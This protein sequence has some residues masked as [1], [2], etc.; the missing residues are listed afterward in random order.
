MPARRPD[1]L[2]WLARLPIPGLA[3][4]RIPADLEAVTDVGWE[5]PGGSDVP[6]ERIERVWEGVVAL[7]RT[8]VHPAL[9]ICV[10]RD[11]C[12]VL[13]RSIGHA[14]GNAPQDPPDAPRVAVNTEHP[15][16]IFSASKAV[17]AMLIHKLDEER[18]LHLEDPVCEFIPEFA[19]HGKHRITIRHILS[20][21]AGIPNLPPEA[22]DLD[23][24]GRPDRV[25][26]ILADARPRTRPG[27][28]LAYH[29]VSGGFLLAEVVRRA[30]G[31]NIRSV[32][33]KR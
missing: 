13:H 24:L 7:Y 29:A 1:P 14:R 2:E 11:G 21:R 33:E 6:R 17:T 31:E 9:Q 12:V 30:T 32:L 16:D 4:C 8:G 19:R 27:R 26:E 10:R 28:V 18:L 15:F 3:R 25:V 20:H 23:L 5:D 22:I